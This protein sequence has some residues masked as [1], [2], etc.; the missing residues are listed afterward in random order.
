MLVLLKSEGG[1]FELFGPLAEAVEEAGVHDPADVELRLIAAH[2]HRDDRVLHHHGTAALPRKRADPVAHLELNTVDNRNSSFASQPVLI[3]FQLLSVFIEGFEVLFERVLFE[4]TAISES[5]GRVSAG[6][7]EHLQHYILLI[8][9][10]QALL[11]G[12]AQGQE[13]VERNSLFK[14]HYC[15]V[16]M[17]LS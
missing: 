9:F 13:F 8:F 6:K 2:V 16:V 17:Q 12:H 3:H 1:G 15:V 10:E 4:R 7:A 11:A 14:L 5:I